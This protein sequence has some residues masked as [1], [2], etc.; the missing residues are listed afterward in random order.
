MNARVRPR[1]RRRRASYQWQG[2]GD[3]SAA[4]I[5]CY[6]LPGVQCIET[7]TVKMARFEAFVYFGRPAVLDQRVFGQI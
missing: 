7:P 4:H 5:T 1:F 2:R 6:L 3:A